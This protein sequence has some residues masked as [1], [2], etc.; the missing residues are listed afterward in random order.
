MQFAAIQ[1][2]DPRKPPASL[3][4]VFLGPTTDP[5]ATETSPAFP[6]GASPVDKVTPPEDE[7]LAKPVRRVKNPDAVSL[8]LVSTLTS[9]D[10]TL[11]YP[12]VRFAEPPCMPLPARVMMFP[13]ETRGDDPAATFTSPGTERVLEPV[14]RVKFPDSPSEESPDRNETDPEKPLA[15][16]PV[17]SERFPD[18]T[19]PAAALVRILTLPLEPDFPTPDPD[20]RS[21]DPP[22]VLLLPPETRTPP[23]S[24]SLAPA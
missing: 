7:E 9:P 19:L 1:A 16:K 14:A 12:E 13:P 18:T 5:A 11:P 17:S 3:S 10:R 21:S 22:M 4:R 6:F 8:R 2:R 15:A 20:T 23:L 24:L